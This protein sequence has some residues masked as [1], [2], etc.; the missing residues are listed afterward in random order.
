MLP[1]YLSR[2]NRLINIIAESHRLQ[3]YGRCRSS[4]GLSWSFFLVSLVPT[5]L[6]LLLNP[7]K[8]TDMTTLFLVKVV[9]LD[10]EDVADNDDYFTGDAEILTT[11]ISISS[12]VLQT[13]AWV[14]RRSCFSLS[15]TPFVSR[16]LANSSHFTEAHI[17]DR[18]VYPLLSKDERD[19]IHTRNLEVNCQRS[20]GLLLKWSVFLSD[21]VTCDL[22]LIFL[23]VFF[24]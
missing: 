5:Q 10:I 3:E 12:L 7:H 15:M 1:L 8:T 23:C 13:L 14:H 20:I 21:C 18:F 11:L 19:T 22:L 2:T 24:L 4:Q 17:V 16:F 6:L 9:F